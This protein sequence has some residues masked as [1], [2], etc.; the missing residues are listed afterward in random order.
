MFI[1]RRFFYKAVSISESDAASN[2]G[3]TLFGHLEKAKH[4]PNHILSPPK[5]PWIKHQK[6]LFV[7]RLLVLAFAVGFFL[8]YGP[9][10]IKYTTIR[11]NRIL[12]DSKAYAHSDFSQEVRVDL[13]I[14]IAEIPRPILAAPPAGACALEPKD[15]NPECSS[16]IE[17]HNCSLA[18]DAEGLSTYWQSNN[19]PPSGGHYI[20]ID[21][22][23]PYNVQSIGVVSTREAEYKGGAVYKHR[24]EVSTNKKDWTQVALGTWR[25]AYGGRHISAEY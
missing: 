21:L 25:D 18:T 2:D 12:H 24:V 3:P 13:P 22:K 6:R 14:P 4:V 20:I 10:I 11:Y 16:S 23:T 17:G 1:L 15:W 5:K 8:L 19:D 7:I 9:K